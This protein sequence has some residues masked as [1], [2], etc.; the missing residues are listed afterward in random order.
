MQG[1]KLNFSAGVPTNYN[2]AYLGVPSLLGLAHGYKSLSQWLDENLKPETKAEFKTAETQ[3]FV[4]NEKFYSNSSVDG[5][6]KRGR[7]SLLAD[8]VPSAAIRAAGVL[9]NKATPQIPWYLYGVSQWILSM[10]DCADF[11]PGC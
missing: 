7:D 9:G 11:S 6:L 1:H 2:Y 10:Y 3:C 5:Y 4:S 8:E